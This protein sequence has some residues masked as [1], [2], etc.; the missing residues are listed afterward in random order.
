MSPGTILLIITH[1]NFAWRYSQVASQRIVG[2]WPLWSRRND[3][4]YR[5][6]SPSARQ[7]LSRPPSA[8]SFWRVIADPSPTS[9]NRAN[10]CDKRAARSKTH[11]WSGKAIRAMGRLCL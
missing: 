5:G 4:N 6:H 3:F 1:S 2:L 10:F 7:T 9:S 8:G 11:P